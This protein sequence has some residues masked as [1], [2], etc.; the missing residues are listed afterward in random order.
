MPSSDYQQDYEDKER[1]EL[2]ILWI[3]QRADALRNKVS[4]QDVLRHFGV[5]LK[6]GGSDSKEQICCPFHG[7]KDPSARVYAA[8]GRSPSGV[9]CWVCRKRWDIFGL[10]KEFNGDPEMK[11]TTVLHGLERAFGLE[12]PEAPDRNGVYL[13]RGPTEEEQGVLDLLEVCEKRL[14]MAKSHFELQGYLAVGRLLDILHYQMNNKLTDPEDVETRARMILD[15]VGEKI[16]S[17]PPAPAQD[18]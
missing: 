1:N 18:L 17:V 14:R 13:P 4:A 10:W 8:E 3:R 6:R 11:F 5:D 16:R 12:T 9:Y 7:D 2:F 15:K